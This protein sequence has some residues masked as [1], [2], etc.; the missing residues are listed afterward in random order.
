MPYELFYNFYPDLAE[1]ETRTSDSSP[2]AEAGCPPT[3]TGCWRCIAMSR[4]ATAGGSSSW[5]SG[6]GMRNRWPMSPMAGR[7]A[8]FMP[9]GCIRTPPED[10]AE[11]QGPILYFASPQLKYAPVPLCFIEKRLARQSRLHHA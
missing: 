9:A 3:P 6:N 5:S 4:A 7:A 11:L 8:S 10:I 2:A 1:R